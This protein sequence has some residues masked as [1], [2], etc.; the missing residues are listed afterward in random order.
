M[1]F[2]RR[3]FAKGRS[4]S[5][6][7]TSILPEVG[8]VLK[9]DVDDLLDKVEGFVV[10]RRINGSV[11]DNVDYFAGHRRLRIEA[12]GSIPNMSLN[13]LGGRFIE[14]KHTKFRQRDEAADAWDGKIVLIE[15]YAGKYE[16]L[17]NCTAV[18]FRG[19]DL[20]RIAIPYKKTV[21][22]KGER[23]KLHRLGIDLD[24]FS[25]N[26]DVNL[27]GMIKLEHKPTMLNYWHLVMDIYPHASEVPIMRTEAAWKKS[28]VSFVT[29]EILTVKFEV[30]PKPI[31]KIRR[32][33]YSKDAR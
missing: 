28:I 4:D 27:Q 1:C 33:L 24:R 6:Y 25:D 16:E 9:I 32:C 17:K 18:S 10:S 7:P 29:Q 15:D 19:K 21:A 22:D 20:H 30:N 13:L 31:P 2:L 26:K 5:C 11:E 14:K 8:Y 3:C 23:E 12:L